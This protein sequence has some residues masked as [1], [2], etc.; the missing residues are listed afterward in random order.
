MPA[1]P[2]AALAT[3]DAAGQVCAVQALIRHSIARL[4]VAVAAILKAVLTPSEAEKIDPP[5]TTKLPNQLP[6]FNV[7]ASGST[8]CTQSSTTP[9]APLLPIAQPQSGCTVSTGPRG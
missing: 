6:L 2:H 7:C 4:A 5:S 8:T 1:K 9:L 3:S